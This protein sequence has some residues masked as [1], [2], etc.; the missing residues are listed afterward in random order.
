MPW[1]I[2]AKV[3]GALVLILGVFAPSFVNLV[4]AAKALIDTLREAWE[5]GK[6]TTEEWAEIAQ[7]ALNVFMASLPLW[8]TGKHKTRLAK[9]KLDK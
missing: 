8:V 9:F 6:V 3:L 1:E 7:G 4:K 5:D 2:I